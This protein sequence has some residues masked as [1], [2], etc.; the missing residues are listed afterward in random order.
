MR[1]DLCVTNPTTFL[2][3]MLVSV[4]V[5]FLPS[6]SASFSHLS[7]FFKAILLPVKARSPNLPNAS[8][9]LFNFPWV[10]PSMFPK[11]AGISDCLTRTRERAEQW[12]ETVLTGF[13]WIIYGRKKS[14]NTGKR[15]ILFLLMYKVF[16]IYFWITVATVGCKSKV[17]YQYFWT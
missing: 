4:V 17:G 9:L 8:K 15:W 14:C 12:R 11:S 3:V 2:K 10:A 6:T 7:A 13:Q 5:I 16:C 1:P